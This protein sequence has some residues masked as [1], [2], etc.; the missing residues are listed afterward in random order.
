[1]P[2][3]GSASPCVNVSYVHRVYDPDNVNFCIV[4]DSGEDAVLFV[5]FALLVAVALTSKLSAVWVLLAGALC[6]ALSWT[7]NMGRFSNA[8]ALWLGMKPSEIFFYLF[9]PPLLMDSAARV[10]FYV[11]RK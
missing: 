2:G 5:A 4:P 7:V 1:M 10:D 11:F 8:I 9:L 6:E 3:S